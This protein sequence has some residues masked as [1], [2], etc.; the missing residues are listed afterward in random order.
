MGTKKDSGRSRD[1][2]LTAMLAALYGADVIFFAPI[3]FQ[4]VQVRVADALLPLSILFGPPAIAGLTL[5]VFV[6]NLIGSPFGPI[7]IVGGTVANF[8]ATTLAWLICK[9]KFRWAWPIAI[10]IEIVTVTLV[11]GSYLVVLAL[12][13]GTP[14]WIGWLAFFASEIVPIG[15]VGY[16]LLKIVDRTV[17]RKNL[18]GT[19][20]PS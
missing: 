13:L 19:G 17:M 18:P 3:G 2:A 20:K 15:I 4:L 14:L 11:V 5:G 10:V 16:P 12:P 9:K 8:V 1:I 6:G 7:D